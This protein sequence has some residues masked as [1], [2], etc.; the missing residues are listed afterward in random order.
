MSW[1]IDPLILPLGPVALSWY[2]LF[3]A[4]AFLFGLQFMQWTYRRDGRNVAELDRLLWYVLGGTVIGMRL[5]HCFFYD[6]GH[7][8]THPWEIPQFWLGGYSSHG[9]AVGLVLA[10]YLYCRAPGRPKFLWL[11]DRLAVPAVLAGAF[12]R[13]G[14][15]FNSEIYGTETDSIF[16][17][18]FKRVDPDH[19]IKR[20]P[21]QLYEA[22]AYIVIF[23]ALFLIYRRT[24]KLA[25]GELTG[26]YFL[27]V[28]SARFAL[29]YF[30]TPQAA[31]EGDFSI[32]VGQYLSLP[33][34][35][36][37][38]ILL[39]RAG[40]VQFGSAKMGE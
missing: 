35:L 17:V 37:G 20:H 5:G 23:A 7:Y 2:G 1:D 27:L 15:F 13:V 30:K 32:H 10:I 16:G 34:V 26:F 33:F 21:V 36:L 28:F 22:F 12:I 40:R 11:L 8:L 19:F 9:G 4:G 31:Y 14:N 39:V 24:K 3:F 25:D 18:W 29:E 38:V 6:P